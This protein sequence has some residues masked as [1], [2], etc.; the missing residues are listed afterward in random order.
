MNFCLR[1]LP[2]GAKLGLLCAVIVLFGGYE[3]AAIKHLFEHHSPR[4]ERPGFSPDDVEAVYHGLNRPPPMLSL[5]RDDHAPDMPDAD[6]AILI[7]WLESADVTTNFDNIDFDDL[8]PQEVIASNCL[9][10]HGLSSAADQGA[11]IRLANWNDVKEFAFPVVINPTDP[12]I[13][14]ASMHAHAPTMAVVTIVLALLA[15]MSG[16]APGWLR[17][18]LIFLAG[19]A[20]LVDIASWFPAGG[21]AMFAKLILGGGI[22]HSAAMGLLMLIIAIELLL[23]ARR[24]ATES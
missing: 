4:D 17:G 6:R 1:N 19:A 13:L 2:L 15:C 24:S 21:N 14:L 9:D 7:K 5:L 3:I 10:C 11:D 20:L 23:P 16:W 22:V 18:L 12:K 8:T